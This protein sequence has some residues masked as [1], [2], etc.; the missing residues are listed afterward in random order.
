MPIEATEPTVIAATYPYWAFSIQTRGF[1]CAPPG[2]TTPDTVSCHVTL[3][4][5]RIRGD[6][7]PEQSPLPDDV[8]TIT[9]DDIYALA[10][11]KPTVAAAL[12]ALMEAVAEV[13]SDEGVR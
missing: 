5:F 12:A 10:A 2:G 7:V 1:P 8:R 3:I 6:G 11:T 4:K 13:A 9:V